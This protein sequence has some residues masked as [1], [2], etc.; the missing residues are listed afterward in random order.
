MVKVSRD[1]LEDPACREVLDIVRQETTPNV[2]VDRRIGD[3]L[4]TG[5]KRLG[6]LGRLHMRMSE[7][8]DVKFLDLNPNRTLVD[9][10]GEVF[11]TQEEEIFS[12]EIE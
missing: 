11:L 3:L 4:D 12:P 9:V 7:A 2:D 5:S 10:L 6:V 8:S 1:W